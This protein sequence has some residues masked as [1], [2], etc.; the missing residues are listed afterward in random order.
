[1][2][3]SDPFSKSVHDFMDVFMQRSMHGWSH[4]VKSTGLSMQQFSILMQLHYRSQCGISDIS[5]RFEV[6]SAAAS[7]LA[8][9]LVQ[10]GLIERVES[11]EDRRAKLLTLS[12]KGKSLIERGVEERYRWMDELAVEL[13]VQDQKKVTSA[14][15]ILT[16]AA[17]RL[18]QP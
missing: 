3:K 8:D 5:E 7:Q 13:N 16:E 10:G 6:T 9:K 14:L 11:P 12:A 18:D 15:V 17:R 1:M 2:S 4:F